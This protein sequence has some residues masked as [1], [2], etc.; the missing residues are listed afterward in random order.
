MSDR[1]SG[2]EVLFGFVFGGLVGAV[3]ALLFAPQ[4][5]EETRAQIKEAGIELQDRAVEFSGEMRKKAE[6][7]SVETQRQAEQLSQEFS[8]ATEEWSDKVDKHVAK[9]KGTASDQAETLN[10]MDDTTTEA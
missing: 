9:G 1:N 10:K 7:L 5:G 8:K 6:E 2:G 4:S 3:L